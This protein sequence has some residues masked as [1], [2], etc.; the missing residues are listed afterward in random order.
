MVKCKWCR[1]LIPRG[2][3]FTLRKNRDGL[4]RFI[5]KAPRNKH[6]GY[7]VACAGWAKAGKGY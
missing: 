4:K 6:W 7:H 2:Y 5:V 1:G 3:V